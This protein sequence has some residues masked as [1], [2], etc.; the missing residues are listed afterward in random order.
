LAEIQRIEAETA[1]ARA[2]AKLLSAKA[3]ETE[4]T[5]ALARA[6]TSGR[7]AGET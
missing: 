6:S 3:E 4:A 7:C 1:Q 5:A 2:N